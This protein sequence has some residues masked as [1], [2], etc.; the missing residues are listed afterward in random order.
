M[1]IGHALHDCPG[2]VMVFVARSGP[3]TGLGA[4]KVYKYKWTRV[5]LETLLREA[6]W[7]RLVS[8]LF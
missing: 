5:P 8:I 2:V 3:L 1:L 4:T 6:R 7:R